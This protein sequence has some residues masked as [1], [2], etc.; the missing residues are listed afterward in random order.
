[1]KGNEGEDGYVTI[2]AVT[3]STSLEDLTKTSVEERWAR[4]GVRR[5]GELFF[6]GQVTGQVKV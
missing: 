3:H 1:M 4:R 6:S 5:E 2:F